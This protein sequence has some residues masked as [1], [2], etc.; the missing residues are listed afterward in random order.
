[1]KQSHLPSA[2]KEEGQDT[3]EALAFIW[4]RS[5]MDVFWMEKVLLLKGCRDACLH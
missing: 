5:C 2:D 3:A 4:E 1:M